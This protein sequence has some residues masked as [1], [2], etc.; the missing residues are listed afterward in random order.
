MAIHQHRDRDRRVRSAVAIIQALL[1]LQRE[2]PDILYPAHLRKFLRNCLCH[3]TQANGK[4]NLC[5]RSKAS[6]TAP[7][8]QCQ[9]E[10][11]FRCKEMVQKLIDNPDQVESIVD[12]AVGCIVTKQEHDTLNQVDSDCPDIDGW[13]RYE[14]AGIELDPACP[15][16]W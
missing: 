5:Y 8:D 13:D 12:G 11:V 3:I 10:H 1:R 2:E 15:R 6:L 14:E 9:H 4:R 16:M 7:P